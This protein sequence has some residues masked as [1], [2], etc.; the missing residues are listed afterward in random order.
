MDESNGTFKSGRCSL[1]NPHEDCYGKARI[2]LP[3]SL[4]AHYNC[5][6]D[7]P[8]TIQRKACFLN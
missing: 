3:A 6:R 1:F 7:L 4:S 5:F 2:S 8:N